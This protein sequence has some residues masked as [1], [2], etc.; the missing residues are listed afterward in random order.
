MRWSFYFLEIGVATTTKKLDDSPAS[1]LISPSCS[2][3]SSSS[4][5]QS[6]VKESE[7][8]LAS[9]EPESPVVAEASE[10]VHKHSENYYFGENHS[11]S[12]NTCNNVNSPV[13]RLDVSKDASKRTEDESA[14]AIAQ[15]IKA[16][17]GGAEQH[18]YRSSNGSSRYSQS[19]RP[20]R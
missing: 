8:E 18:P 2:S 12:C 3:T 7:E 5:K 15:D 4:E 11:I 10:K 16:K 17:D 1:P 9:P 13:Q 20:S 14:S 19:P 6:P